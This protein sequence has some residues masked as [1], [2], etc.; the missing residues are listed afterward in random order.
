MS[1]E[2]IALLISKFT[3]LA[4]NDDEVNYTANIVALSDRVSSSSSTLLRAI[5]D[6][7]VRRAEIKYV[8][9]R[10]WGQFWPQML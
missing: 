4:D 6:L 10:A 7:T 3:D 8:Q 5:I 2:S 9:V 1:N